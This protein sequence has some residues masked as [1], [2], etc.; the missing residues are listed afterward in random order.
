MLSIPIQIYNY[1]YEHIKGL[2]NEQQ[3]EIGF[4][5]RTHK[6]NTLE[7]LHWYLYLC[8][9]MTSAYFTFL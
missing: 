2:L 7:S 5:Y 8:S 3:N 1:D 6:D 9:T 4:S